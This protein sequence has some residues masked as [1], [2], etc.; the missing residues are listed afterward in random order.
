M[1]GLSRVGIIGGTGWLGR[2]IAKALIDSRFLAAQS[3]MLSNRAGVL[4]DAE[5]SLAGV[6]VTASNQELVNRSDVVILSVRPEDL[7]AIRIEADGKL[8]VSLVAGASV[9]DLMVH[10]G[11]RQVVRAMPNAALEIRR[12][13]T[14]WLASRAV[15]AQGRA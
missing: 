5:A 2:S 6:A 12:A 10:T 9:N 8:L 11:C 7:G 1:S 4:P 14:P 3:L 15:D 13:Y